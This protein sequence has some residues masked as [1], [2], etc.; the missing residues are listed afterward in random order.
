MLVM[1]R[2]LLRG[3]RILVMDEAT[4]SIDRITEIRLQRVLQESFKNTTTITIAHRIDT[5]LNS[6][7]ILVMSN[8]KVQEFAPPL[9]LLAT[10]ESLFRALAIDAGISVPSL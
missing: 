8:G 6:D 1:S 3:A 9:Q 10:K 4:A 7:R 5:I 2:A